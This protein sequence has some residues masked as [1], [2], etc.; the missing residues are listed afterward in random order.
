MCKLTMRGS[1][2]GGPLNIST[3]QGRENAQILAGILIEIVVLVIVILIVI[4]IML[5]ILRGHQS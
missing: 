4:V 5:I 2:N 3:N 1:L